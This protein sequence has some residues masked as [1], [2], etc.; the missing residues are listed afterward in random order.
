[1]PILEIPHLNE[2]LVTRDGIKILFSKVRSFPPLG[3]SCFPLSTET[4]P[5][6]CPTPLSHVGWIW[7]PSDVHV[8]YCTLTWNNLLINYITSCLSHGAHSLK[9]AYIVQ[10]QWGTGLCWLFISPNS[11]QQCLLSACHTSNTLRSL[12]S[13]PVTRDNSHT[14]TKPSAAGS[15]GF[16]GLA[17]TVISAVKLIITHFPPNNECENGKSLRII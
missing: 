11:H 17:Q 9:R 1:M 12:R 14:P 5:Y 7:T 16:Y 10:V 2:V 8:V 15:F 6:T 4:M 3:D 13:S